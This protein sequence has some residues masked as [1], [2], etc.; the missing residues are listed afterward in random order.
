MDD[1][2]GRATEVR[3]L[4]TAIKEV[5]V[6]LI[7]IEE[8]LGVS[9]PGGEPPKLGTTGMRSRLSTLISIVDDVVER[10]KEV[11]YALSGLRESIG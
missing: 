8:V 9:V 3:Q 2:L 5:D 1:D 10:L 4:S 7:D 6:E 11:K